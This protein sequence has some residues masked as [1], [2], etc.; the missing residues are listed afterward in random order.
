VIWVSA[1]LSKS[2]VQL[3]QWNSV[4]QMFIE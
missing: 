4:Q 3:D 2:Q 1:L